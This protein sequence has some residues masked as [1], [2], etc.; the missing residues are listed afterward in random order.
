MAFGV[1][2]VQKLAE[3]GVVNV[4]YGQD[5]RNAAKDLMQY[6]EALSDEHQ[7][8]ASSVF[9]PFPEI[10]SVDVQLGKRPTPDWKLDAEEPAN[11]RM[12]CMNPATQTFP[13]GSLPF[14]GMPIIPSV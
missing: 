6:I 13:Q 2:Q 8:Q 7:P 14:M 3:E 1:R 4:K 10:Q 11:K 5:A 12:T 9:K